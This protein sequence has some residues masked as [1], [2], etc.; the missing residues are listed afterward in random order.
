MINFAR[1]R[2]KSYVL[3]TEDRLAS[4]LD[5]HKFSPN[6]TFRVKSSVADLAKLSRQW[7]ENSDK[8]YSKARIKPDFYKGVL[9][10][11]APVDVFHTE[12]A[13][14]FGEYFPARGTKRQAAVIILGHWNADAATYNQLAN[15][16]RRAGI[17]ALRLTLPYHD[18]RRPQSM[19]MASGMLSADLD[20]T[21]KSFQQAVI[22]VRHG[23]AWL[24]E[25]GHTRIGLVGSSMGSMVG[26]LAACHEPKLKAMVGYLT[27][28]ELAEAIWRGSATQHIKN[29]LSPHLT[30]DQLGDVWS[31][32][33]P[34]MYISK[35]ARKDFH[36]HIAWAKYDTICPN[37]LTQKM[38]AQFKMLGVSHS[39]S[40]YGC[41]HNTLA[42]FP[43]IQMAGL[44]GLVEMR[45]I[46]K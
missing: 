22:E 11:Q 21:I 1:A 19:G 26:L 42:M 31:C 32:I 30:Q 45:R 4:E 18:H 17:S 35:L 24:E 14:A 37:D 41:G 12:N 25:R 7:T 29:T 28:A 13:E 39:E 23:V 40:T 3:K 5:F 2:F 15:H 36:I 8:F 33:D 16:Y 38:L 20:L 27:A 6:E 44:R 46:L 10:F 34:S 9:R 43:F